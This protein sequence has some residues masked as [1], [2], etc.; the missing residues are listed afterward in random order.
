[1]GCPIDPRTGNC[2]SMTYN[3][4]MAVPLGYKDTRQSDPYFK[5][6]GFTQ[7]DPNFKPAAPTAS[8]PSAEELAAGRDR[9]RAMSPQPRAAT[10]GAQAAPAPAP[11]PAQAAAA[12]VA[13][14]IGGMGGGAGAGTGPQVGADPAISMQGLNAAVGGGST[15][16]G[17]PNMISAPGGLRSTMG[18][19]IYPDGS[20]K[21][22]S[23][24]Y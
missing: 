20:K 18:Q 14:G 4:T 13:Q 6:D 1:M 16:P 8:G 7:A 9:A 3:S 17:T 15:D 2:A 5:F 19:R 24:M 22:R 10:S 23:G 21:L 11:A 12:T